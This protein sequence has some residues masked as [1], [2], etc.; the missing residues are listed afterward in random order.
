MS[1]RNS[2]ATNTTQRF[3]A[4]L[5]IGVKRGRGEMRSDETRNFLRLS[6]VFDERTLALLN[7]IAKHRSPAHMPRHGGFHSLEAAPEADPDE[8]MAEVIIAVMSDKKKLYDAIKDQIDELSP[9]DPRSAPGGHEIV[10]TSLVA[11][12]GSN[13]LVAPAG[14]GPLTREDKIDK[15]LGLIP[16]HFAIQGSE[17]ETLASLASVLPYHS[18]VAW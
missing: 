11:H 13:S 5:A 16:Y 10:Y 2:R 14:V 17:I 18:L 12:P 1:F 3:N 4:I 9:E 7:T 15:A 8:V 6:S